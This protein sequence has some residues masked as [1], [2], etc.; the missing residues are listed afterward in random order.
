MGLIPGQVDGHHRRHSHSQ[1]APATASWVGPLTET[2]IRPALWSGSQGGLGDGFRPRQLR[3]CRRGA[4]PGR[5]A[6]FRPKHL[7]LCCRCTSPIRRRRTRRVLRY[8]G[9]TTRSVP[10][11]FCPRGACGCSG[12]HAGIR[13]LVWQRSTGLLPCHACASRAWRTISAPF[14]GCTV[15][16]RSPWKTMRGTD[17]TAFL[18]GVSAGVNPRLFAVEGAVLRF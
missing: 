12:A 1:G 14:E 2:V 15:W 3:P 4:V 16:S 17:R 8:A 9:S 10:G 6:P 18:L 5:I 11:L 7:A 13:R